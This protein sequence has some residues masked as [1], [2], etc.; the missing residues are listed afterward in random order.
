MDNT[1][2]WGDIRKDFKEHFLELNDLVDD[3]RPYKTFQ[4]QIW[5]KTGISIGYDY[6]TKKTFEKTTNQ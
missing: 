5:L 1:L 6:E 4:I 2:T 3:Y